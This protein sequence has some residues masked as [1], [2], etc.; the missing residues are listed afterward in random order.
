MIVFMMK[1]A[2]LE[3]LLCTHCPAGWFSPE[4]PEQPV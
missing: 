1:M 4:V 3:V 2:F